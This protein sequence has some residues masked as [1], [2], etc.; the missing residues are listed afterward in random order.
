MVETTKNITM[1]YFLLFPNFKEDYS[2]IISGGEAWSNSY[3]LEH[4]IHSLKNIF[5]R[6]KKKP[7]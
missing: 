5:S 7:V 3:F 6:K 2:Q 1:N 4:T